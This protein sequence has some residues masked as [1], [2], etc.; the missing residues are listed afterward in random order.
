MCPHLD[1]A[2]LKSEIRA[3]QA[4]RVAARDERLASRRDFFHHVVDV[5]LTPK[6]PLE[7]L[8]DPATASRR[9]RSATFER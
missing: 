5:G 8:L 9:I 7:T 6:K 3:A 4:E 1:A 2:R